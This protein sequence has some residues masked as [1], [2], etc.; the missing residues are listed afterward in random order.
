MP[1]VN[2]EYVKNLQAFSTWT[3]NELGNYFLQPSSISV[4]INQNILRKLEHEAGEENKLN[5]HFNWITTNS[6]FS[7][8]E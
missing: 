4:D 2:I 7:T 6:D 1:S 8:D 3:K 5:M